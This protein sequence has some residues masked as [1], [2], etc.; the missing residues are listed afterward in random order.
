MSAKMDYKD[1]IFFGKRRYNI[2]NNS[3]GTISLDDV[4]EYR[5]EGDTFG[6]GDM[7]KLAAAINGFEAKTIRKNSDGS[8]DEIDS[9]G[10]KKH[11]AREA[12]GSITTTLYD[13]NEVQIAQKTTRR[14]DDGSISVEVV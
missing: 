7:N 3:D 1:D 8:I 13:A 2:I 14:N 10:N 9:A 5:Q 11:T 4:T 12:D 6:A